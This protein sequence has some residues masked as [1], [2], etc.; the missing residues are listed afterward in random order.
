MNRERAEGQRNSMQVGQ[1]H[2]T[3]DEAGA[4]IEHASTHAHYRVQALTA[5]NAIDF[6]KHHRQLIFAM[7]GNHPGDLEAYRLQPHTDG[8]TE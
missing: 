4:F 3:F 6:M 7:I 1:Y 8:C 2:I 5:T